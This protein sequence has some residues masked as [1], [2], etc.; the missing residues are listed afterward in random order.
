MDGD[1]QAWREMKEYN[2]QDVILLEELYM[3]LRP[4]IKNHPNLNLWSPKQT[5]HACPNCG[6]EDVQKRGYSYTKVAKYQRYQCTA[7]GTWSKSNTNDV[8]KEQRAA[9]LTGV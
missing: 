2:I 8:T 5:E 3:V 4:W 1:K 9:T 7:C 6:S